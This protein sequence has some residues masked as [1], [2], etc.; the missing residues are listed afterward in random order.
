MCLAVP[1]MVVER[2]EDHGT[3]MGR[4]DYGGVVHTVCLEYLPDLVVGEYV[5]VHAGFAI[6]RVDTESARQTLADLASFEAEAE[7]ETDSDPE[8]DDD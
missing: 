8:A 3:Q 4:V 6:T 7:T 5:L 1:G 2:F